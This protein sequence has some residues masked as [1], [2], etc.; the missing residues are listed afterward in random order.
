MK[1]LCLDRSLAWASERR[2]ERRACR[3][4][5]DHLALGGKNS[6]PHVERHDGS[7]HRPDVDVSG[8]ATEDMHKSERDGGRHDQ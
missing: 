6:L 2:I 3:G 4:C 7:E 5:G 8:A 1:V